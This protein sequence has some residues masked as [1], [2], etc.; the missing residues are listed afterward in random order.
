[1]RVVVQRVSRASVSAGDT[2]VGRIDR[3]L[4]VLV[5]AEAGDGEAAADRMAERLRYLRVF[6]DGQGKMNRDVV[7]TGGAML[8]VSQFTLAATTDRGRRPSF[9]R[10]APPAAALALVGRLIDQ[11]RGKGLTV[12]TGA[13]G[14]SMQVEL[15][16]DGPVTFV[17]EER[18]VGPPARAVTSS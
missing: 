13:F 12:A 17:L 11:L 16:N 2:I 18:P 7:E 9:S 10:A 4:L 6:D 1:M 15:V 5:A 14:A 3:G 8:V